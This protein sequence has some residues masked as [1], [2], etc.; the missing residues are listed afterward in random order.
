MWYSRLFRSTGNSRVVRMV[1][2]LAGSASQ[3]E[4]KSQPDSQ[5]ARTLR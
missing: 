1:A 2:S 4:L 5:A 3:R